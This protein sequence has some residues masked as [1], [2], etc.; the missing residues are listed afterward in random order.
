[1]QSN[2]LQVVC[3][4]MEVILYRIRKIVVRVIQTLGVSMSLQQN[5]SLSYYLCDICLWSK[6][7]SWKETC[8]CRMY[9]LICSLHY[10]LV[11]RR[12]NVSGSGITHIPLNSQCPGRLLFSPKDMWT[13][14]HCAVK[15][16]ESFIRPMVTDRYDGAFAAMDV[17]TR[18]SI[19]LD[20]KHFAHVSLLHTIHVFDSE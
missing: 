11:R 2:A 14:Q 7:A 20:S 8:E 3:Q 18:M 9:F 16:E 1:M 5:S 4:P 19:L 15:C 17:Q 6:N 10:T 12:C 13:W